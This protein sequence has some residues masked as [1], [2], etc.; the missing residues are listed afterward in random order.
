M[1]GDVDGGLVGGLGVLSTIG[2]GAPVGRSLD[3]TT[4]SVDWDDDTDVIVV[5]NRKTLPVTFNLELTRAAYVTTAPKAP[6]AFVL[7]PGE[8]RVIR[9]VSTSSVNDMDYAFRWFWNSGSAKAK[10]KP[11]QPYRLPWDEGLAFR[12]SQGFDGTFSHDEQ[13]AVDIEMPVGTRV[14]AARAGRVIDIVDG[15]G[16]G[17]NDPSLIDKANLVKIL[18]DDGTMASYVHLQA[19]SMEVAL[20]QRVEAGDPIARSG[21]SGFH[22]GPHLH[23]VV[24]SPLDGAVSRTHPVRFD[25]GGEVLMLDIG[26]VYPPGRPAE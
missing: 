24:K 25:V 2:F 14:R 21:D 17:G 13:H 5:T 6:V 11:K 1:L 3:P 16:P 18:H 8:T 22:S 12:C 15:W 23:F 10:H 4:V 20:E 9:F 26:R 19:G 7:D